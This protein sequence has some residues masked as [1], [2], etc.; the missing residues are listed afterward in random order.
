MRVFFLSDLH[1]ENS[2]S[3]QALRFHRFLAQELKSDDILVLGG[4]IFDLLVG[5]KAVFRARYAEC[6]D[7][8][9]AAAKRGV[10]IYYLEG[11]HDFHFAA[12]FAGEKNVQVRLN[13]FELSAHGHRIW[14]SHGDLIDPD[15][16]GYR[17]LR[18]F[19]KN[20]FFEGFVAAMPDKVVDFIGRQS[21]GA[22]RKY[23]TS[24]VENEGT[25]RLRRLYLGFARR[26][27]QEGFQHVLVGHSHLRDQ[28]PIVENGKR[29]EYVNLGFN[30]ELL[31]YAVLDEGAEAFALR[32]F[33]GNR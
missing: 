7:A 5:N 20:V 11:N 18:A 15:D 21:S 14:V 6:L 23:T 1:L 26:K 29:G 9:Q 31:A 13:D 32:E 12:M 16:T 3:E 4:D 25:E 33:R 2:R 8:I 22:S 19:T 24:R 10:C 28:V 17:F 30:G 27:V